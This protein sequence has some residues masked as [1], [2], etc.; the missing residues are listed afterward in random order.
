M[1]ISSFVYCVILQIFK[2]KGKIKFLGV[3]K[4]DSIKIWCRFFLYF[5]DDFWCRGYVKVNN[6]IRILSDGS[7]DFLYFPGTDCKWEIQ[8]T[9]FI[10]VRKKWIRFMKIWYHFLY[11]KIRIPCKLNRMPIFPLSSKKMKGKTKN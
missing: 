7:R 11:Q 3:K 9:N 10:L 6:S 5:L 4:Y 8:E 2:K 1:K